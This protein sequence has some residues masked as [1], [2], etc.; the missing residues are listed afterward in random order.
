VAPIEWG[1]AQPPCPSERDYSDQV[2]REIKITRN[3]AEPGEWAELA[4]C[5]GLFGC[6]YTTT[7]EAIADGVEDDFC[8]GCRIIHIYRP[9]Q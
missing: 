2:R 5:P 1:S 6:P 8:R 4:L 9:C 3:M 7:E